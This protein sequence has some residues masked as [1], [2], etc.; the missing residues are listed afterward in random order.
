[1]FQQEKA[2][3]NVVGYNKRVIAQVRARKKE[4][5]I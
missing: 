2:W 3:G 4:K 5:M 1:M